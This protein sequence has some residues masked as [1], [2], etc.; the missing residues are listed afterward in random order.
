MKIESSP[1]PYIGGK[2]WLARWLLPRLNPLP[3]E[4]VSPFFGGGTLELNLALQGTRVHGGDINAKLVSF[5]NAYLEN[6]KSV[7]NQ[8]K[9][10]LDT[11]TRA[12]LQAKLDEGQG[13]AADFFLKA[14][15]SYRGK[16]I[17]EKSVRIYDFFKS[18]GNLY[19]KEHQS[20]IFAK[21]QQFWEAQQNLPITVD[22]MDFAEKIWEFPESLIYCDPPY[23]GSDYFYSPFPFDHERLARCL[24]PHPNWMLSYE[25]H[26]KIRELYKDF[27]MLEI[28]KTQNISLKKHHELFIF[29]HGHLESGTL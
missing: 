3:T 9:A 11:H 17:S 8:A 4:I 20:K 18:E 25:D 14:R 10:I 29:S 21:A 2:T 26:P 24:K 1:L 28:P 6:P 13:G 27:R 19:L 7:M 15:L 22:V 16:G 5:W 23:Y 12:S